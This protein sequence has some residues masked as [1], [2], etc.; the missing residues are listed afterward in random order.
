VIIEP[1]SSPDQSRQ[2]NHLPPDRILAKDRRAGAGRRGSYN[3]PQPGRLQTPDSN[4]ARC[5]AGSP[6]SSHVGM[7][8][9]KDIFSGPPAEPGGRRSSRLGVPSESRGAPKA[10]L[11]GG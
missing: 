1:G 8:A 4:V 9:S 7:K 10:E 5:S 2:I 3:A 11:D 6:G